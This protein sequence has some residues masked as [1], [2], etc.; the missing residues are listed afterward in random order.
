[1]SPPSH[2]LRGRVCL[3][4]GATSGIGAETA[5]G[6]AQ[7]GARVLIGGRS[8]ARAEATRKDVIERS[9]NDAVDVVLGDFASLDGV[10]DLA[11]RIEAKTDRLHVL[12]NNAGIMNLRRELTAD[13]FEG[14]FGVNHLAP[15][16]LTQLLLPLLSASAPARI[17]NVASDAHRFGRFELD[18]LQSEQGFGFPALASSMRVYGGSK[19]C[20]VLFTHELSRRLEGTG[21][22]A[23]SLHPGSVATRIGTQNGGFLGAVVPKLLSLFFVS[24]A[25][26]AR[27]SILLAAS[28]D[29]EGKSGGYY[30]D[31]KQVEPAALAR[32]DAIAR[33]LW[34][35]SCEMVG[36]PASA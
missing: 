28:P 16:L 34:R 32:D 29:L 22:T 4:T 15:F 8:E 25:Q 18:D 2:E 21:V 31:E 1:M 33:E 10:R 5:L 17:V 23:N 3:V 12:V 13:G 35:R 24:P 6:L 36:L 20:N 26:G 19:L 11:S 14:M 27:T 9:G 7:R 30:T